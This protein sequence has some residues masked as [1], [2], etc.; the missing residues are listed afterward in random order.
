MERKAQESKVT[1]TVMT[2][3]SGWRSASVTSRDG[4]AISFRSIGEGPGLVI[5]PGNNRRAHHYDQLALLLAER[6]SVHSIDRRGRGE[7]GP[8]GE[9]YSAGREAEDVAAV[10]EATDTDSVFGHSYGGLIALRLALDPNLRRL[11]VYEPGVSINGG[12]DLSWLPEFDRLFYRGRCVA[13]MT[14]FLRRSRI[15]PIGNAPAFV[16]RMLATL[17]LYG[18][19][20]G[21]EARALM[22]TTPRELHEIARL[23]SD[24]TE[25]ATI[26]AE[27]LL[28]AGTRTNPYLTRAVL[29][30]G[31]ILPHASAEV[32]EG[33]DHNAPDLSAIKTIG[34][35]LLDFYD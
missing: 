19:K 9:N 5:V 31:D 23:D 2:V 28:L 24:G 26:T 22:P 13:A 29:E 11:A 4:T 10:L 20:D 1:E 33:L 15:V 35:R 21:A 3:R 16:Y 34:G 27:T 18:G 14:L 8:Q 25:Y 6:H 17:L 7:S 30:L 12:F 32:F